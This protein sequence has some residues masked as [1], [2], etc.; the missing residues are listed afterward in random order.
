MTRLLTKYLYLTSLGL[1]LSSID[2]FAQIDYKLRNIFASYSDILGENVFVHTNK[3]VYFAGEQI[4]LK[5]YNVDKRN[6]P[7]RLNSVS[8][9]EV[10]ND[11]NVPVI[12]AKIEL[13][14]GF[15]EGCLSLPSNIQNGSYRLRA[16]TN[17]MKNLGAALFFEK[18]IELYRTVPTKSGERK[19][20]LIVNFF[21]EGGDL[22]EGIDCN[23]GFK[24]VDGFEKGV[25]FKGAIVNSKSDTIKKISTLKFGIG[26]FTF[27]PIVNQAYRLV[28][29][30]SQGRKVDILIP[31]ALK[32]GYALQLID[33]VPGRLLLRAKTTRSDNILS[34]FAHNGKDILENLTSDVV[35]GI[36]DFWIDKSK[37]SEGVSHLTIFT[38]DGKPVSERLYFKRPVKRNVVLIDSLFGEYKTRSKVNLDIKFPGSSKQ[39][40]SNGSF[41]LSIVKEGHLLET[42]KNISTYLLLSSVVKGNIEDPNYYVNNEDPEVETALDNLLIT[43]GWRRFEWKSLMSSDHSFIKY[44]PERYGEV[45]TGQIINADINMVSKVKVYASSPG[46]RFHFYTAT[47]DSIG[48]FNI[49]TNQLYGANEMVLQKDYLADT[50]SQ[51]KLNTPFFGE[52]NKFPV[53]TQLSVP[54]RIKE[55]I[56][57]SQIQRIYSTEESVVKPYLDTNNFYG[58]PDKSYNLEEYTKFNSIEEVLREYV[59]EVQVAKRQKRFQFR[60]LGKYDYPEDN[61]LVLID[62]LPYFDL[63]KLVSLN[64]NS[65]EKLEIIRDKYYYNGNFY[66]G[67]LSF[68]SKENIT[69]DEIKL[70]PKAI[71]IDYQ[72][73]QLRRQFY[74]PVYGSNEAISKVPDF[75]EALYWNPNIAVDKNGNSSVSFYTSDITGKYIGSLQGLSAD[76]TPLAKFFYFNVS[77]GH[78]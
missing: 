48:N 29:K 11:L 63:D 47:T 5:V 24:V 73:L 15:G 23:V 75:R 31:T 57:N 35:K 18:Q 43:Q 64:P 28:G 20:D 21:P 58:K 66:D 52:Y 32:Q 49:S 17:V 36:A 16:Y 39:D 38:K 4:W 19:S 44:L 40:V 30:D 60:I 13:K 74:S 61:P 62:G 12:Q 65:I 42:T 3:D 72:G 76:G 1:F 10:L 54:K 77:P 7:S 55:G 50:T 25:D 14:G 56:F 53:A 51:I 71:V 34:L 41:S 22:L 6:M 46:K 69:I 33:S 26:K 59:S 27:Q 37:L 9:I 70:N 2:S 68:F 78:K 67:I 45:I 8:Y